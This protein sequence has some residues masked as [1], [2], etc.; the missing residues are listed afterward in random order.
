M[1]SPL[2]TFGLG[3]RTLARLETLSALPRVSSTVPS[4]PPSSILCSSATILLSE[5]ADGGFGLP[6]VFAM[7]S[8]RGRAAR[9][10]VILDGRRPR[11]QRDECQT[12]GPSEI[13]SIVRSVV[14][15]FMYFVVS[16]ESFSGRACASRCL[17]SSHDGFAALPPIPLVRTS[18]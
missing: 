8:L 13:W 11:R 2:V 6:L 17:I 4:P 1:T 10:R 9:V 3:K 15:D 14:T 18:A 12:R 5:L 7:I 16:D